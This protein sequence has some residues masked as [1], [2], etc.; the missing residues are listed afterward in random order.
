M[1]HLQDLAAVLLDAAAADPPDLAD[2]LQA[3][4][5]AAGQFQ[6]LPVRQVSYPALCAQPDLV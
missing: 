6:R 1:Q 5:R 4:R 2:A 3:A